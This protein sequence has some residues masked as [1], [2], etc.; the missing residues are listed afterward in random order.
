[1]LVTVD[2]GSLPEDTAISSSEDREQDY[3][4]ESILNAQNITDIEYEKI[5]KRKKKGETTTEENIQCQRHYYKQVSALDEQTPK[6]LEAF[7]F[8]NDP[9]NNC[10][11]LV[12]IENNDSEDNLKSVKFRERANAVHK[13]RNMSGYKHVQ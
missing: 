11:G 9:L 12:D 13:L 8:G 7:V 3:K 2:K 6:D 10:L 5:D 4:M 1:M